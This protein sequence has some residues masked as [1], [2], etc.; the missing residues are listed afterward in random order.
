MSRDINRVFISGNI[1]KK[2]EIKKFDSG[3]IV[4][5]FCIASKG[6]KDEDDYFSVRVWGDDGIKIAKLFGKLGRNIQI[7]EG[8]IKPRKY[9]KNGV[10][11]YA[12][13][14]NTNTCSFT[15][16]KDNDVVINHVKLVED[17]SVKT[18]NF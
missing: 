11:H 6:P 17:N 4:T 15:D 5:E 7:D 12:F 3:K 18:I 9:E 14:I 10:T 16:G 2:P 8:Y 1:V 13:T